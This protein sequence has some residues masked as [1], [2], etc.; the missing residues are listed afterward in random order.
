[1]TQ[2]ALPHGTPTAI[3]YS[4]LIDGLGTALTAVALVLVYQASRIINFAQLAIGGVGAQVAFQLI[5]YERAIPFAVSLMLTLVLSGAMGAGTDLLL[6]RFSRAPRLLATVFTIV[7]ASTIS[8]VLTPALFNLPFLP[9]AGERPL[10]QIFGINSL[11]PY[12]PYS[13]LRYH[14]GS[15]P[16][17][18]GFAQLAALE[19]CLLALVLV[20]GFLR[21]TRFGAAIRAMA[22]NP[23][24]AALLGISVAGVATVVWAVAGVLG[25]VASLSQGITGSPE[26]AYAYAPLSLLP[27]LVAAVLA[28]F[29]SLP[30]AIAFALG[31][32][33]LS[34]AVGY[35]FNDSTTIVAIGLLVLA[36]VGLAS[37][38]ADNLR[39]E[40]STVSWRLVGEPR[41]VPP[42]LARLPVVRTTRWALSL[43][44]LGA[45]VLYPIVVN[46]R[47]IAIGTDIAV[48]GLVAL[49]LVV[50]TGWAGQVSLGQGAFV[51]IGAVLSGGLTVHA[52]I[53]FWFSVP[54]AALVS[55]L[56]AVI[57]GFPA[58]RVPGLYLA[59]ITFAFGAA[60]AQALFD[61][62]LFGWLLPESIPRPTLFLLN[63]DDE[64]SMY[65]LC[66]I[67]LAAVIAVVVNL[68][69]SR[70]G[71]LL[72]ATRDNE[73]D[74]RA[75]G[76]NAT[77]LKLAGFALSG[78]VAGLAGALEAFQLRAVPG[79]AFSID[80]SFPILIY[81]LFGGVTSVSG[82]LLGAGLYELFTY[83]LTG[84]P[85]LQYISGVGTLTL[86]YLLPSGLMSTLSSVRDSLLHI[87][88]VRSG[89]ES[90]LEEDHTDRIPLSEPFTSGGLG[91]VPPDQ[92]FRLRSRL[93]P[94]GGQA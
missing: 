61:P 18:F 48:F 31:I 64:R 51:A 43:L 19:L 67:V 84:S 66:L 42:V 41:P 44:I 82:G 73:A 49:S 45:A 28:R 92:R 36:V 10:S 30:L 62:K 11:A 47:L 71:R 20:G 32:G 85:I 27:A 69:R 76:V 94:G 7:V 81:T 72:V 38:R 68:R 9:P 13:G 16:V 26:A 54:I 75:V 4:G 90:L 23:E 50:L 17:T 1:M 89:I 60:A 46:V 59:A 52:G 53:P 86:V 93:L 35:A 83:F 55:G 77:R 6:R 58:L 21:F 88:A 87:V 5:R 78:T 79:S 22:S 74:V 56:L 91:A 25:G 29:R 12:L 15:L 3:L 14:V 57:I 8:G 24:R 65:F 37:L 39:V 40:R 33:V 2:F 80:A 63:F 34:D 70:F